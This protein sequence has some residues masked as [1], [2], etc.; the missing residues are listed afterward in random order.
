MTPLKNRISV[1]IELLRDPVLGN[2]HSV[3]YLRKNR[4][5]SCVSLCCGEGGTVLLMSLRFSTGGGLPLL[6]GGQHLHVSGTRVRAQ[7]RSLAVPVPPAG[8]LQRPPGQGAPAAEHA[9]PALLCAGP[10]GCFQEGRPGATD[11]PKR[12]YPPETPMAMWSSEGWSA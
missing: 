10:R 8:R 4:L 3:S 6:P 9:E 7:R 2:R 1:S 12:R 5:P 11:K